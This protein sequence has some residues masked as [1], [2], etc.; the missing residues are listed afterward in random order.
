MLMKGLK[1]RLNA[2]ADIV[3]IC[4]S[5][6]EYP[7]FAPDICTRLKRQAF[8]VVVAGNP[9][10]VAELKSIGVDFFIHMHIRCAGDT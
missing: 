1:R 10:S 9:P 7:Q 2:K 3:V 4:S 5:D 6:E 8:V